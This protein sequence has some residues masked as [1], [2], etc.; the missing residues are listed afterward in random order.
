MAPVESLNQ[1]FP[2]GFVKPLAY[3]PYPGPPAR[4]PVPLTMRRFSEILP[5][6][7]RPYFVPKVTVY[8]V[9]S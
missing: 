4:N 1:M 9:G 7:A 5:S 8:G 6:I 3:E 2:N